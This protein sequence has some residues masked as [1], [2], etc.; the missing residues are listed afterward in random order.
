MRKP[1]AKIKLLT[2]SISSILYSFYSYGSPSNVVANGI[3]KHQQNK[4]NFFLKKTETNNEY[5]QI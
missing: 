2:L 3:N 1:K 5:N 4:T